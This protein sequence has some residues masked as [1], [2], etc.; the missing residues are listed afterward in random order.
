MLVVGKSGRRAVKLASQARKIL[1]NNPKYRKK[2]LKRNIQ[3]IEVDSSKRFAQALDRN[4][5]KP[6]SI[7]NWSKIFNVSQ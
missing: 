7:I 5:R 3:K 2:E 4:W 1:D 6:L